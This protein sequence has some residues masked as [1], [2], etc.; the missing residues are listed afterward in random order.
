MSGL[1]SARR[2]L[3]GLARL[4]ASQRGLTTVIALAP[5]LAWACSLPGGAT[6]S[7]WTLVAVV[8]LAM[9]TVVGPDSPAG[10][11]TVLFLCWYWL[12]HVSTHLVEA[13]SPWALGA[14]LSL[15]AFHAAA[16]ARAT[17]PGPADLDRAFWRRWLS[18]V[19]VIAVA[20]GGVWGL[21]ALMTSAHPGRDSL[22]LAAFGVLIGGTAYARWVVVHSH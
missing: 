17:A 9:F 13:M 12:T 22:T 5:L 2:T 4:S 6:F 3:D 15:L 18:R 14:S 1:S 8:F 11:S 20:T 19:A 16:A 21:A 10:L 7:A